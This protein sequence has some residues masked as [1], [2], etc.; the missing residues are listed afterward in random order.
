M[1]WTTFQPMSAVNEF[2][3]PVGDS[4]DSWIPPTYP[5]RSTL[6]GRT[7]VL[8]PLEWASHGAGLFEALS[9]SEDAL[10]TYMTFGPFSSSDDFRTAVV[11]MTKQENWLPYAI[12]VDGD[13]LGFA[14]YLRIDPPQG[15]IEIGAIVLSPPLQRTTQA[16]EA[17]YLMIDKVFA[18]GYRRCEWKCDSL[19]EPSRRSG[20]RLGFRYEGTFRKG[21][22]Y[23]GRNRD[24]AWFSMTDDEW[25]SVKR[26]YRRWLSPDNFDR[27][28]MQIERLG[29]LIAASRT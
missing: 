6:T 16:T 17:L 25:P 21:M 19:N 22:H 12:V 2:G 29:D 7:T 5:S 13:P 9:A 3:Q 1:A 28:G 24:T 11:W 15:V 20:E 10:W 14:S 8:E 26:A 4:I 27:H 18:L 23:K